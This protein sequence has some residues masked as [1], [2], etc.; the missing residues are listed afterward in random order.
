MRP[1]TEWR[2]RICIAFSATPRNRTGMTRR[3]GDFESPASASSARVAWRPIRDFIRVA[4][5][6]RVNTGNGGTNT[7]SHQEYSPWPL[8]TGP[9]ESVDVASLYSL[10]LNSL[11]AREQL[12]Q[13]EA[14]WTRPSHDASSVCPHSQSYSTPR[15]DDQPSS[16]ILLLPVCVTH[17]VPNVNSRRKWRTTGPNETR[18]DN[19]CVV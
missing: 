9:T 12:H 4:C 7:D 16:L 6:W 11:P 3:S 18:S 17:A 8:D 2:F 14:A 10:F 13:K 15:F 5:I 19:A 1:R